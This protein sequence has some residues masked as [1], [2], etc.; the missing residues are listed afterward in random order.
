MGDRRLAD[1]E[2]ALGLEPLAML[3][4]EGDRRKRGIERRRGQDG[5]IVEVRFPQ[6]VQ[7]VVALYGVAAISQR[8]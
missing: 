1:A 5:D 2:A 8:S 3:I 7:Y 4:D 6:R